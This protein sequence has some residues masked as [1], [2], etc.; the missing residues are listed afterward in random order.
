MDP[1]RRQQLLG[2]CGRDIARV[3]EEF[4]KERVGEFRHRLTVVGIP[5]RERYPQQLALVIDDE[6]ECKAKEP[7]DRGAPPRRQVRKDFMLGDPAVMAHYQCRR[8]H[9]GGARTGAIAL[10]ELR[11]QGP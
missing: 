5:W 4:A 10:A 6:V 7:P 3:R 1:K 11:T 8:I 2:Q 9:K